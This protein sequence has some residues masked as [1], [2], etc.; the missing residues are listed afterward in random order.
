MKNLLIITLLFLTPIFSLKSQ[1]CN[2]VSSNEII[3]PT[4][5]IQYT[6]SYGNGRRA[7]NFTATAG[8][9][10]TFSTI[11]LT[12]VD[13]YL[14]LYDDPSG[15]TII[16]FNDDTFGL[17]SELV[18]ECPTT[19]D[20]S[21]LL[22]RY[23]CRALNGSTQLAYEATVS[24][25]PPNLVT[26]G[27][28]TGVVYD[29]PSYGFYEYS[30]STMIYQQ[31]EIDMEGEITQIRFNTQ[32]TPAD[33]TMPNQKIYMAHTTLSSF[34]NASVEEAEESNHVSSDWTLVYDGTLVWNVGWN[35][36]TL[37]SPFSWNNTDNLLIKVENHSGTFSWDYPG[38]YYT[39]NPGTV[40]Y[41]WQD[42]SYPFTNGVRSSERPNIKLLFESITSLPVEFLGMSVNCE[43]GG[44]NTVTWETASETNSDY[45]I[46]ERSRDGIH[47]TEVSEIKAAGT[48]NKTKTYTYYDLQS[49]RYFEGYYQLTQ[50]DYDGLFEIFDPI[51]VRCE[52]EEKYQISAYPN[53]T[54]G[55]V[56]I[57]IYSLIESEVELKLTNMSGQNLKTENKM[58]EKGVN[59]FE[60]NLSEYGKGIYL[61]NVKDESSVQ[62]ISISKK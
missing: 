27:A 13:T 9:T 21:I 43:N 54:E 39:D 40:A 11:G 29:I 6:T 20:Y 4:S 12:S 33:Y 26:I 24:S 23:N 41:N 61:M 44:Y 14:R 7:F 31:S 37:D 1:Y 45:F 47:W 8:V 28:G 52:T 30:W 48:S 17:Q 15:G 50:I 36:I 59:V 55:E 19:G 10:Y 56:L 35:E 58:L 32:D 3:T 16:A 2:T 18:W 22:T 38:F 51:S 34:P 46:L 62:N 25:D 49:G 53:P 42:G 60:F 57:T 5:T